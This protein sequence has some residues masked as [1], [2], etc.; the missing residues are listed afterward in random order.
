M[1]KITDEEPE[2]GGA[3]SEELGGA[4]RGKG[5]LVRS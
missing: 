4:Q 2:E 1:I 5:P 3:Q